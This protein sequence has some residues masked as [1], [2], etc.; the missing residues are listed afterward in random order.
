[1]LLHRFSVKPRHVEDYLAIWRREVRVRQR[2]GYTVHRAFVETDAEPKFTWL[3]SHRDPVPAQEAVLDDPETAELDALKA[4]H[5]FRNVTIRPVR[6][7]AL[8][9]PDADNIDQRIAIMRRYSITGSWAEF[10]AIWRQIVPLREKHG[11]RCL[12]AVADEPENMFTWAFD[13][14]GRFDDFAQAQRPYYQDPRRVALR[15]VFDYMADYTI[16]PATQL[17]VPSPPDHEGSTC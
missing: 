7:E 13:F 17:Q 8:T 11:F 16:H 2:H 3:Y 5:V 6:V 10:L 15:G 14:D 1:M 12:F 9:V 4:N